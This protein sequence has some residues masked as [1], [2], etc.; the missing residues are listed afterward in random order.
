MPSHGK[1][2][3]NGNASQSSNSRTADDPETPNVTATLQ[4]ELVAA[5]AE[6]EQLR[7][8]LAARDSPTPAPASPNLDRL[9]TVLEAFSERLDRIETRASTPA[10]G[11]GK[12]LKLPDPP[13]FTDGKDPTFE[14]WRVQMQDKLRVNA[15]H[16]QSMEAKKAYVFN[17]TGGDAQN[18]LLPRYEDGSTDPFLTS[19]SMIDFLATIYED[20]YKVQNARLEYKSLSMKSTETFSDFHTRFLQLAG[21]A[22]IPSDDLRPDLFDKLTLELQRTVLPVYTTLSTEKA[23]ADQCVALDNGLRRIRARSDRAK[24]RI[25]SSG[26]LLAKPSITSAIPTQNTPRESTPYRYTREATPDRATRPQTRDMKPPAADQ[27][28]CYSCGQKGHYAPDCPQ[29]EKIIAEVEQS[30]E[31]LTEQF[32]DPETDSG[33]EE[34]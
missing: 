12:P 25:A 30:T 21:Q 28:T 15:D 9:A 5:T 8:Q 18:H 2:R 23:L 17:R 20:P 16:F 14:R 4:E 26:A 34:P 24:A 32:T 27:V 31:Q 11:P 6:I 10:S 33:K 13:A 19:Q 22:K 29:K 1:G 3:G 7:A